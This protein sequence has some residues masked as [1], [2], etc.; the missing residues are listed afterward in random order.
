MVEDFD[1]I[2][3]VAAGSCRVTD[4]EIVDREIRGMVDRR[5]MRLQVVAGVVIGRGGRHTGGVSQHGAL[6]QIGVHRHRD[7]E[8]S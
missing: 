5:S 8:R 6:C 2:G 4:T 7:V 3:Q 1:P